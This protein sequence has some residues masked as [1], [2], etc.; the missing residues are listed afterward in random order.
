MKYT[1]VKE[2][3]TSSEVESNKNKYGT[4][5]LG[6]KSSNSFIKLLIESLGD[7]IIKILLIALAIK[8]IFLIKSFDWYETIGIVIAIF[9]A[10]FISSISEYGSEKAFNRLQEVMKSAGEL[11]QNAPYDKIV[12]NKYAE[13]IKK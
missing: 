5:D 9:L 2:G 11:S 3:L 6:K 12:N 13:N 8:V 1:N 10:S 7:P 4:N